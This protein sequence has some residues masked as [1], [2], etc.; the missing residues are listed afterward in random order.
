[1][2][3]YDRENELE[4]LLET[5]RQSAEN[6]RFTVVTGRRRIGKTSLV[7]KAYEG[8]PVLYFFV[9]RK[10][11]SELCEAYLEEIER[12]LSVPFVG[13][14][15]SFAE[16]FEL[17]MKFSQKQNF[18][19]FIDE[20][21]E[22]FRVNKSVFSDM[23]RIW[24]LYE[25]ESSI[26]LVVCG[27][28]YSMMK[29]IFKDRKEPLYGRSTGELRLKP[30]RPSVLKQILLDVSPDYSKEDLLALYSLTGGVAKYVQL[31]IDAKA[32]SKE[33]MINYIVNANSPMLNEG[34]NSLIEEFGRDYGVYFSILSCIARGRNT[35]SEIEDVI[36]REVGGYLTNLERE[37]ELI[38]K[39]QPMFEKSASKNVRYELDD[40]FYCF[41]F[42]F[43]FKYSYIIEIE[44]FEKLKEI[45]NRDYETFSGLMLERYFLAKIIEGGQYTRIGRWW[46]RKGH[47]EIDLIAEDELSEQVTFHE[48]KRNRDEIRLSDL[49]TKTE[50]FLAATHAFKGYSIENKGLSME[51]M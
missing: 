28:V 43:I 47:N 8:T 7:L 38:K 17:L 1:M 36:G 19:V 2:K 34:K 41:W 48:I 9:A 33:A 50:T 40:A 10:S 25:K 45:I 20:F 27:S 5:Y 44:N 29:K 51:D 23:Q 14:S 24:D 35:R 49:K 21:Q 31:L 30:F 3:F 12:V 46:D 37:Y 18:T 4:Y 42:R 15:Q 39:R 22:F 13:R 16:V 11:E 26:N 32:F 6:A